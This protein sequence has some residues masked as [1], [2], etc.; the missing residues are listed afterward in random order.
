MNMDSKAA[1]QHLTVNSLEAAFEVFNELSSSLDQSYRGLE[2]RVSELNM[3]LARVRSERTRELAEKE[4]L[5][6]RLSSLLAVLPGGVVVIDHQQNIREA[7]PEAGD[8]LLDGQS[9]IGRN[10]ND[11]L[12]DL[13]E[14][15][16]G[17]ERD[18]QL[19]NGTRI[20]LCDRVLDAEGHRVILFTD[21]SELCSLQE[22]VNRE[23]RLSALGEM[24]ARLAHQLRT[25]LSSAL[26]YM[27]H[28][29]Q[30]SNK[31]WEESRIVKKV[32]DRLQ[33]IESLIDGMLMFVRGDTRTSVCFP[34]QSLIS[35]LTTTLRPQVNRKGGVLELKV[36]DED[37]TVRGNREALL[38]GLVNIVENAIG[39]ADQP[40]IEIEVLDDTRYLQ[41][42]I[43]DDGP[44]IDP[45]IL[46]KIFDPFFTTRSDG[47]GLGLAIAAVIAREHG[48]D[49]QV[50]NLA[51][52]GTR[53]CFRISRYES[54]RD[55]A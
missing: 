29:G 5:A 54:A 25:P 51:D 6:N 40:R 53:F 14:E 42:L 41:F 35:E 9:L 27:S 28:F 8:L 16:A 26:L 33:H 48:G 38:S 12:K 34:V 13:V 3:E 23:K 22:W 1:N 15:G 19:K 20:S 7:N 39:L 31:I 43:S 36:P 32:I 17:L 37:I 4:K 21:I 30:G 50:Q 11:L 24:S 55:A 49:V 46:D 2:T 45:G 47:T 44:G 10:W 52:G 18:L